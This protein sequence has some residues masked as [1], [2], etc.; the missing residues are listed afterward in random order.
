MRTFLLWLQNNVTAAQGALLQALAYK[1]RL[2]FEEAPKIQREYMEKIGHLER[3]AMEKEMEATLLEK[4][5]RMIQACINRREKVDMEKI[6]AQLNRE[7]EAM[8]ERAGLKQVKDQHNLSP[9]EE[10][11]LRELYKKIVDNFH[12]SVH[13]DLNETQETLFNK[14][15]EA[16]QHQDLTMMKLIDEMLRANTISIPITLELSMELGTGS[17]DLMAEAKKLADA[18][19]EDYTLASEVFEHFNPRRE[20]KILQQTA[21]D[22]QAQCDDVLKQIE[23]MLKQFPFAARETLADNQKTEAY[24]INVRARIS[25]ADARIA[26]V[27]EDIARMTEETA[28]E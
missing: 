2:Q 23:S 12:P 9:E 1:D 6:D 3:Q 21:K 18:L 14:A 13:P 8:L 7:R 4:K 28:N 10:E 15:V 11:E 25:Q 24:L 17:R 20:E 16:Y 26:E 5:E 22:Y 19:T 27:T